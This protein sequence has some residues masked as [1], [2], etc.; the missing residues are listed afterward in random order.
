MTHL[1]ATEFDDECPQ[2]GGFRAVVPAGHKSEV[3]SQTVTQAIL[4]TSRR[5]AIAK[6]DLCPAGIPVATLP[7][8]SP[9]L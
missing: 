2:F 5:L 6:T 1:P 8:G 3:I 9:P 7:T 4:A